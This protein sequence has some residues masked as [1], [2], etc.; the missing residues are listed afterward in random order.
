MSWRRDIDVAGVLLEARYVPELIARLRTARYPVVAD[1]VERAL[2]IGTVHVTFGAAEREAIVR[3]VADKPPQ[4][5]EL[6]QVL[7]LELE[8][9]RAEGR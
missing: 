5:T 7:R 4:F 8:R 2:S 6:Y 9:R 1:K 3:A